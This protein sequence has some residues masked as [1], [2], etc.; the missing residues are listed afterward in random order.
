MITTEMTPRLTDVL[1]VYS[2]AQRRELVP[3]YDDAEFRGLLRS[4]PTLFRVRAIVDAEPVIDYHDPMAGWRVVG[5]V[6]GVTPTNAAGPARV[7][8]IAA[9]HALGLA[10]EE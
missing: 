5:I 6:A 1:T 9:A 2:G 3:C 10:C 7:R 8:A 4:E